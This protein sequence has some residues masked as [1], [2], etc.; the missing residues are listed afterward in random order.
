MKLKR[1]LII[2]FSIILAISLALIAYEPVIIDYKL[3]KEYKAPFITGGYLDYNVLDLYNITFK[4]N[5]I[6]LA[7]ALS[8]PGA[9]SNSYLN[10][11]FEGSYTRIDTRIY[12]SLPGQPSGILNGSETLSQGNPL[13]GLLIY[14]NALS[15]GEFANVS[16]LTGYVEQNSGTVYNDVTQITYND[17]IAVK[18]LPVIV[19]LNDIKEFPTGVGGQTASSYNSDNTVLYDRDSS[20]SGILVSALLSGNMSP[21]NEIFGNIGISSYVLISL[22]LSKT[23][24][25]LHPV[26]WGYYLEQYIPVVAIILALSSVYAYSVSRKSKH[27]FSRKRI[28]KK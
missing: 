12:Y 15:P 21:L 3:S 24:I 6:P 4:N 22:S 25:A 20:G 17:G 26:D 16:G 14:G 8:S 27:N 7:K 23:N 18:T 19:K 28:N 9:M 11:T 1:F 13:T 10:L 5:S 2:F